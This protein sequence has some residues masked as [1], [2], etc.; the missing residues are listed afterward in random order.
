MTTITPTP[1]LDIALQEAIA[2]HQARRLV[3]AEQLYR[4]ILQAQ[5]E[6]P[7]ANHNLG[8]LMVQAGQYAAG[9][10]HLKTALE[11]NP[12]QGQYWLSYADA[13]LASGQA[14]EAL[15]VI[16]A[17]LQS[18]LDTPE[19]RTLLQKIEAAIQQQT[20]SDAVSPVELREAKKAAA[21]KDK[22]AKKRKSQ[23]KLATSASSQAAPTTTE[24]NQIVA[25]FNAGHH[26]E[27]ERRTRLLIEQYPDSGFAWK[28]LGASLLAQGKEALPA[29]QK[30]TRLLPSDAE[31]HN[32][33][34][35]AL[36]G[37]GQFDAAV[38]SYQR[39]LA[40]KP[41]FAVAYNNLGITLR[42]LGQLDNAVASCR[43]ALGINP[44][45]ASAYN[46]LGVVLRDIGQLDDAVASC[47]RALEIK[48]DLIEAYN[49]LGVALKDLGQLDDAVA[50][51]RRALEIKPDSAE[52]HNNL[53]NA[54]KD[55]GQLDDAVK[56]F[57]RALEV[58]P[59]FAEAYSNLLFVLNFSPDTSSEELVALAR[60][61]DK[62]F[63]QPHKEKWPVHS[64][65]REPDRRLRIGYVSPD[66]RQHAVA[67]FLEPILAN[68]DKSRIEVF[69]YAE[70]KR[71]DE[72]T[73]RFR[74]L[75]DHWH[76]TCGLSDDTVA[77]MIRDHQID[78]LVDLA[79]HTAGNRLPVFAR[80]P[81]PLQLT[82][83]GYPGTTGLSV[84]DYRI[85]DLYADPEGVAE[86][87]YTERLLRLPNSLWCYR[88]AADMPQ[89]SS[90]PALTNGYLTF[91]SFNNLNKID[92]PTL[93]LWAEL[94]VHIPTAHLMI[95]TVP[96][97][98]ARLRL[99]HE[100][101]E[102]GVDAQRLEFHGKFAHT[103][104]HRKFL[105]V[106]ISLD[107]VN[108]NGAT[109]TC[110]SLWMGVPVLSLVSSRFLTRAGLSLLSAAGVAEF[111]ADSPP[112]YIRIAADLAGNLSRL[113][114][115]RT[116]LRTR[117]AASPL[118]DEVGFTRNLENIYR[119]IWVLWCAAA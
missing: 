92:K 50:N 34:G 85:T 51:Y 71:E 47:R 58:K 78:I 118:T 89:P 24:L 69:C 31:A 57:C 110:E 73:G 94:L 36:R 108:V 91:G 113:A 13:L 3:E 26:V 48:P 49:N 97:G 117:L 11:S 27:L 106:D 12:S 9:L 8:V 32:N 55:L 86:A 76:S 96:V 82:Y 114:E 7:D 101:A 79:G 61:F 87:S 119:K 68:H 53:G 1:A 28:V 72:Y 19:A 93:D 52:T 35:N 40:I 4:A 95:L 98:D 14:M 104:F 6:Q 5:P 38:V 67:I 39:A 41:D 90:L 29:L 16:Q 64:N 112:D 70:V 63:C 83:L 37:I 43:R 107:P 88:P 25:L 66:F 2:H 59:D 42:D 46:N 21:K 30:A 84:M 45:Y 77:E 116:G 81:A 105:E 75:A 102:R 54:L 65:S 111:A 115:I 80:K 33:L 23:K 74:Q 56:S 10:P 100:F 103:E 18:G 44:K 109:T 17:A 15:I 60:E 62:R 99:S 20:K 22:P